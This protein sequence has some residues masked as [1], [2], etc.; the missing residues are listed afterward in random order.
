MKQYHVKVNGKLYEVEIEETNGSV[1]AP[2][3]ASA[4]A[5][6]LSAAPAGVPIP[7]AGASG[8]TE[9][10]AP[11]SGTVHQHM[12]AVGATVSAGDCILMLEAMKM[13]NEI[14]TPVSGVV[15]ELCKVGNS[16]QP[17]EVLAV[18]G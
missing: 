6:V 4:P 11:M 2:S 1:A 8:G 13:Q 15:K 12:V 18:I 14:F 17:N 10:K 5:P 7:N 9:I 16:V 3:A